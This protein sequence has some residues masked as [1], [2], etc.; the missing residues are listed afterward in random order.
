MK[1]MKG[2]VIGVAGALALAACGDSGSATESGYDYEVI[3]Q[4]SS[5]FTDIS[6]LLSSNR[7]EPVSSSHSELGSESAL[8]SSD[9][10][11]SSSQNQL[12]SSS[13]HSELGSESALSS[14]EIV[15]LSSSQNQLSSSSS[16]ELVPMSSSSDPIHPRYAK[17]LGVDISQMQEFEA[18]GTRVLDVD[19]TPKD[20]FEL[21][22][23]HGFNYVRLKTFVSPKS[24]YGYAEGSCDQGAGTFGSNSEAFGDKEHVVAYAKRAK[25]AGFKLLLDFHYSDNWADPGKQIIPERWR[26][27]SSSDVMADSVYR[28]T[29]D[30]LNA[31][32]AA[33][34]LPEM[35][36]VGNEITNG[37]L[38]DVP[39][40]KTDCWGNDVD[41]AKSSVSG[42]MSNSTGI[43]NTAKYLAA[44][45]R[46]VKEVS[47]S[48]KTVFHIE[49]PHKTS[50]VDWWMKSIISDSKVSPDVMAFSAY[51]A[52]EHGNPDSWKTLFTHLASKFQNLEFLIAEYNG[53]SKSDYYAWDGSRVRTQQVM[54]QVPRGLG[55]FIWEPERSGAWG[56]SMFDW[57]GN[58]LKANPKAFDEYKVLF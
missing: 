56:T 23:D 2:I 40:S 12:S 10:F 6:E 15:I 43:A 18:K 39:N 46:A 14:S 27:I 34:A 53:A 17:I 22:R 58:D 30:V 19:G 52:Y 29:K 48:I 36:Q 26:N 57:V 8:S 32:K 11:L 55:A 41:L 9:A 28:Y 31:L 4:S 1:K 25:A 16:V 49:S 5:S 21:F 33:G 51:T 13:S 45:S 38:R 54:E 50:T 24:K 37:L 3:G 47:N 35:V 20:V 42:V 7:V 44:G